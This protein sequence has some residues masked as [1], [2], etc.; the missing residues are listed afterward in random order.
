MQAQKVAIWIELE[1]LSP[2][3]AALG[4]VDIVVVLW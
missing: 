1:P 2:A 3:Y 4:E